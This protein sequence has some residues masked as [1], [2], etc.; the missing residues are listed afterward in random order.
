MRDSMK[1]PVLLKRIE[2]LKE[3]FAV[4]ELPS[5]RSMVLFPQTEYHTMSF[6]SQT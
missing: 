6:Q 2:K 5:G 1:T 4:Q 3:V